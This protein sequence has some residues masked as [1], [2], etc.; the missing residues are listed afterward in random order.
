MEYKFRE[1]VCLENF[2]NCFQIKEKNNDDDVNPQM[3]AN[4][5]VFCRQLIKSMYKGTIGEVIVL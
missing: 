4:L 2:Q 3:L 5:S 1:S